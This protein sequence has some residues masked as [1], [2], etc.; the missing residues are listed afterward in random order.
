MPALDQFGVYEQRGDL[1]RMA[2]KTPEDAEVWQALARSREQ[3]ESPATAVKAYEKALALFLREGRPEK[4]VETWEA[5]ME[6]GQQ[7]KLAD[8]LRFQLACALDD[9]GRK[10]EALSIFRELALAAGMGPHTE[11]S[12]ARAGGIAYSTPELKSEAAT[13][14]QRLMRDFPYSQW[15]DLA[16]DRLKELGADEQPAAAEPGSQAAD[17]AYAED[18]YGMG[19]VGAA[20]DREQS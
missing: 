4:A 5:M 2:Q 11:T 13:F 17:P 19:A 14:Y 16:L 18:P 6:Y 10:R 8:D 9:C 20:A 3:S 1:E 12:L 7:V 15:R